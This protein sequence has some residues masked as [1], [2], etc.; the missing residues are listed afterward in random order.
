MA[1]F[2]VGDRVRCTCNDGM[3]KDTLIGKEGI[4]RCVGDFFYS[5]EFKDWYAGHGCMG[6]AKEK[7][8]WNC[9]EE[10]LE[11]VEK[12]KP[13]VVYRK[14]NK[15]IAVD[16]NTGKTAVARC[17]P[18]DTYDFYEGAKIAFNRLVGEKRIRFQSDY[19]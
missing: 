9:K 7:Q 16:K 11:L 6:I 10:E 12:T 17:C 18:D 5:V 8:G 4:V 2:K 19:R 3:A 13:I 1:K 14:D 15:T